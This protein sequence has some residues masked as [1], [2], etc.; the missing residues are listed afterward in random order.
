M[1]L[2]FLDDIA[3]GFIAGVFASAFI[4]FCFYKFLRKN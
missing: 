2:S 4:S 1:D 3:R